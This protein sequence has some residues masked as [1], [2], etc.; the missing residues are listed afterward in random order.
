MEK[1][2][3]G[4]SPSYVEAQSLRRKLI[5]LQLGG[6]AIRKAKGETRECVVQRLDVRA[7]LGG[8]QSLL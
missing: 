7:V 1:I 5:R 3:A 8:W 6:G 4:G 2:F